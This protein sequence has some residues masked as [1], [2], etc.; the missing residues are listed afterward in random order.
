MIYLFMRT[1]FIALIFVST[2]FLHAQET[3]LPTKQQLAWH[4]ME[5]YLFVHFGPNT[6]TNKEWGEGTEAE[7]IFNPTGLDCKQWCSI[8]KA[9]GAKGII[10]T[11]KHH[12]GF[13][14]F[15]IT[16]IWN[17]YF[18]KSAIPI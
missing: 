10:I 14:I 4:N 1:W 9:A 11:A 15:L 8:A 18:M 6:F 2:G 16:M 5:Y 17:W 12:D 7:D 3:P 13:S